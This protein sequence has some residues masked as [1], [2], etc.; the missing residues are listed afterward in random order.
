M[1]GHQSKMLA[2]DLNARHV[3]NQCRVLETKSVTESEIQEQTL[4][5]GTHISK[6]T[7]HGM[8]EN[9]QAYRTMWA[10]LLSVNSSAIIHQ[11][12]R[13]NRQWMS[14]LTNEESNSFFITC[15]PSWSRAVTKPLFGLYFCV[16]SVQISF[17]KLGSENLTQQWEDFLG[18]I[19]TSVQK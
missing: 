10:L 18:T 19:G 16:C 8:M 6:L 13:C 11:T 9:T 4:I 17:F 5:A 14:D 12:F 3:H 7:N 15:F 2:L 1:F